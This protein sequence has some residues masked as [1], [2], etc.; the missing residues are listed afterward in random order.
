MPVVFRMI[1][2]YPLTTLKLR[3]TS[4]RGLLVLRIDMTRIGTNR[5][6]I[7]SDDGKA[8]LWVGAIDDLWSLGKPVGVGAV[9]KEDK[10]M[11]GKYS[12]LI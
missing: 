1:R 4:Y 8:A 5:N 12:T 6:I 9:W 3:I 10:V 7:V 11:S 2:P